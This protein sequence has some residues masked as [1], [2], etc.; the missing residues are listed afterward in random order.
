MQ[1]A[2]Y[3]KDKR[4]WSDVVDPTLKSFKQNELDIIC[5]VIEECIDPDVRK[6]PTMKEVV[7]KL[8]EVLR[9]SP[10]QAMPRLSPLWWAELE[11]LSGEA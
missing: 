7:T 4:N 6:R 10:E 1:A 5:E 3:L 2:Q 11:I 8:R 9:I